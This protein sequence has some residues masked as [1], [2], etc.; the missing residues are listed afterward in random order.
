M[1]AVEADAPL[2][3]KE[4]G[5]PPAVAEAWVT[6]ACHGTASRN[7]IRSWIGMSPG[8]NGKTKSQFRVE[9][10]PAVPGG[11]AAKLP[12]TV[13]AGRRRGF[14]LHYRAKRGAGQSEF[15][16][17]PGPMELEIAVEDATAEVLD[18]ELRKINVPSLGLGLT[19]STPEVFRGRTLPEWQ[20][21]A[22]DQKA[23]P[24][25]EREFRRT[26][27]LLIRVGAQSAGAPRLL[28]GC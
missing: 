13:A 15:E 26:D 21:L 17:P 18:R 14:V 20:A 10:A 19:L 25:I 7:L 12:P 11:R 3:P 16:V 4:T 9:S 6:L 27:R 22:T 23:M 5:P 1:S 28:R 8:T 24:V 2:A